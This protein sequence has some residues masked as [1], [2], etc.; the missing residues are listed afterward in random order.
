MRLALKMGPNYFSLNLIYS[1]GLLWTSH[2][3]GRVLGDVT[4]QYSV[5]HATGLYHT[6]GWTGGNSI[7]EI[8]DAS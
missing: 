7:N 2:Y 8:L 5:S 1:R 6:S 3:Q 4:P